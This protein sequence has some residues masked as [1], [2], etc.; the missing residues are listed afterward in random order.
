[1]T[2]SPTQAGAMMRMRLTP[3][4]SPAAT[5]NSMGRDS[6]PPI[7]RALAERRVD[8][9]DRRAAGAE[10]GGAERVEG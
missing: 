2:M 10:L 9:L 6:L 3:H 5:A 8:R 4:P 7:E 1:M